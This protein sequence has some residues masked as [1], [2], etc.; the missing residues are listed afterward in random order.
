MLSLARIV[1]YWENYREMIIFLY[2]VLNLTVNKYKCENGRS[3]MHEQSMCIYW[4]E[5]YFYV[6]WW[7]VRLC[8][9]NINLSYTWTHLNAMKN[10]KGIK[11][12]ENRIKIS[13]FHGKKNYYFFFLNTE[14]TNN[15]NRFIKQRILVRDAVLFKSI[16]P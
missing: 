10:P 6:A 12:T 8:I 3:M 16:K 11:E 15:K 4:C 13:A 9:N 14:S 2:V 5:C 7:D 1:N